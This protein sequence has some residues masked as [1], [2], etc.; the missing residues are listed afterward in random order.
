MSSIGRRSK[1]LEMQHRGG[2]FKPIGF[3]LISVQPLLTHEIPLLVNSSEFYH[4]PNGRSTMGRRFSLNHSV[5][6]N[7][8]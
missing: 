7:N 2:L 6:A 3:I 8:P 4:R 5:D 1:N